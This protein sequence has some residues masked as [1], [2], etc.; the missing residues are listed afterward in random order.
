MNLLHIGAP[1]FCYHLIQKV[2]LGQYNPS[3]QETN[4]LYKLLA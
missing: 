4:Y 1:F 2:Q 3:P